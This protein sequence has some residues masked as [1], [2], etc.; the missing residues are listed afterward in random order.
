MATNR[1]R[2]RRRRRRRSRQAQQPSK[3]HL[4]L[5]HRAAVAAAM[6]RYYEIKD[7][8]CPDGQHSRK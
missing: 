5:K 8:E 7:A 2:R 1:R 6:T 4:K 3:P